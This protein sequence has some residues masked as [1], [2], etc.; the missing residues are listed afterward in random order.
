LFNNLLADD[1]NVSEYL[2]I[3]VLIL[4][5]MLKM[6]YNTLVSPRMSTGVVQSDTAVDIS[7]VEVERK[8]RSDESYHLELTDCRVKFSSRIGGYSMSYI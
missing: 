6:F 5:M 4:S 7:P 8:L 1:D 3:L 2:Q